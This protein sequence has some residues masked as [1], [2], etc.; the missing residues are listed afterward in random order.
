MVLLIYQ[1]LVIA[2]TADDIPENKQAETSVKFVRI[3]KDARTALVMLI[4]K[5]L[6]W[7]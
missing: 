1:I 5:M 4:D 7:P 3:T 6:V 2:N